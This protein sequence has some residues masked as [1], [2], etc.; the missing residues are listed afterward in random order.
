MPDSNSFTRS[1]PWVNRSE[2]H[3]AVGVKVRDATALCGMSWSELN[4]P[5]DHR[6]VQHGRVSFFKD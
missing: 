3:S 6:L 5:P 1:Q 4:A 2:D